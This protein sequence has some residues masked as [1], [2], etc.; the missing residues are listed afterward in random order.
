MNAEACF[1]KAIAVARE[2]GAR[3]WELR[4]VIS[5]TRLWRDQGRRIEA[6]SRLKSIYSWFTE[7]FDTADLQDAKVLLDELEQTPTSE[8]VCRRSVPAGAERDATLR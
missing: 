7:G 3:M 2:Q 8:S 6:H 1:H 4:A 5:L